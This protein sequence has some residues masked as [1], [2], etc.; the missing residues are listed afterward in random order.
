MF[1]LALQIAEFCWFFFRASTQCLQE[2]GKQEYNVKGTFL[3]LGN[4]ISLIACENGF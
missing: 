4:L 3:Q 1:T 2:V